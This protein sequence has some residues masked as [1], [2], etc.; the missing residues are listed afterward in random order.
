MVLLH[1]MEWSSDRVV[2]E[3]KRTHT[4]ARARVHTGGETERILRWAALVDLVLD[5]H[6][7]AA[8]A[9]EFAKEALVVAE[10]PVA[11]RAWIPPRQ[12]FRARFRV[13]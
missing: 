6:G 5:P 9:E 4:R 10:Q 11:L 1:A 12:A 8:L 2:N 3:T 13:D 7:S